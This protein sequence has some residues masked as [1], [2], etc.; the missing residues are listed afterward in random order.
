MIGVLLLF[1][2]ILAAGTI[3]LRFCRRIVLY[4]IVLLYLLLL[5]LVRMQIHV[6]VDHV[7][8]LLTLASISSSTVMVTFIGLRRLVGIAAAAAATVCVMITI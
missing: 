5:L 4:V 6:T 7:A 2:A 8:I 3:R 1:Y